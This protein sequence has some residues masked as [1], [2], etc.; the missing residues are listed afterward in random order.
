M[1]KYQ[2]FENLYFVY[3]AAQSLM[4]S[5]IK[6]TLSKV[7]KIVG[8]D[9]QMYSHLSNSRGGYNKRGGDEKVAKSINVESGIF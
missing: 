6:R 7:E 2:N 4:P 5:N 1:T 9:L 8:C 3:P